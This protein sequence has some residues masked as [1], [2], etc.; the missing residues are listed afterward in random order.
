[1][2]SVGDPPPEL[3]ILLHFPEPVLDLRDIN[4]V[5]ASLDNLYGFSAATA[6]L[7]LTERYQWEESVEY[8]A[9]GS[10][11]DEVAISHPRPRIRT[12]RHESPLLVELA[13]VGGDLVR[14]TLPYY[15]LY[16]IFRFGFASLEDFAS[17]PWRTRE[18]WYRWRIKA[19]EAKRQ[20]HLLRGT[21]GSPEVEQSGLENAE[22]R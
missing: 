11:F 16:R 19:E 7:S 8:R 14:D 21:A 22:D 1:M 9:I 17:A 3:W 5:F 12:L 20:W 2:S 13:A 10:T 15:F 6:F 18:A 4:L